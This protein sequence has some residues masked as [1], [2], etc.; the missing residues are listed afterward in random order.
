MNSTHYSKSFC[1]V[2]PTNTSTT[3]LS[4]LSSKQRGVD[5]AVTDNPPP[6]KLAVLIILGPWE[7]RRISR[8]KDKYQ[9]QVLGFK[10]V[11]ILLNGLK[12]VRGRKAFM[13]DGLFSNSFSQLEGS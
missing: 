11:F 2:S 4:L 13:N 5:L 9:P 10:N 3:G 12:R 7:E 8:G 1:Q 6:S